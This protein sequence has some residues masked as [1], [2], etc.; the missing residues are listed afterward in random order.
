MDSLKL[1]KLN[2]P[3]INSKIEA[4][5]KEKLFLKD[6]KNFKFKADKYYG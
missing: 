4:V 1:N 3:K 6:I 5:G 2:D